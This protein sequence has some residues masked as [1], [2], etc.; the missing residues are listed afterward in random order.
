M[1]SFF[2][3]LVSVIN[4]Y[5]INGLNLFLDSF[6]DFVSKNV[7]TQNIFLSCPRHCDRGFIV[8]IVKY[9]QI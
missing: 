8:A 4:H 5:D 1:Q 3:F 7:E 6:G 2:E 9:F